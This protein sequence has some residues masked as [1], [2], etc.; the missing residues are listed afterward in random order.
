MNSEHLGNLGSRVLPQ[1]QN[2]VYEP[3]L[4]VTSFC[5]SVKTSRV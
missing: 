1:L 3:T 5:Q 4:V 2:V